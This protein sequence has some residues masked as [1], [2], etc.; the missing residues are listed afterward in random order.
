M[1]A[2]SDDVLF[3]QKVYSVIPDLLPV[4]QKAMARSFQSDDSKSNNS[5]RS[6]DS[7]IDLRYRNS[8]HTMYFLHIKER[9][10]FSIHQYFQHLFEKEFHETSQNTVGYNSI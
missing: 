1:A 2:K 6:S 10:V 3:E 7:S 4:N 8:N 5:S 9:N